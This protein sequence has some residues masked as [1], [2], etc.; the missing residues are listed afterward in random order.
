MSGRWQGAVVAMAI[1]AGAVFPAGAAVGPDE[2][3]SAIGQPRG[4]VVHLNTADGE[5]EK[6]L[7]SERTA[8]VQGLVADDAAAQR[9]RR[10]IS[11]A[12]LYGLA[13]AAVWDGRR[14][15]YADNMLAGVIGDLD[16]LGERAPADEE[17][18][19]VLAPGGV[20]VVKRG[21]VLR[22]LSKA[23]PAE[24]DDWGH[25]DHGADGN[26]VSRDRLVRMPRQMQWI[27][28]VKEIKLGGNP[29]G[30][31]P[32]A[33]VRVAGR[34]LV[35]DY[36]IGAGGDARRRQFMLGCYDAFSGVPI[37]K[38]P[39]EA[40][41]AGRRWQLVIEGERIYTFLTK[42]GPL[43]ALEAA[44]GRTAVVY[45]EAAGRRLPEEATH[46]RA[47]GGR[48]LV[49]LDSG[50]HLLEGATG[51]LLWRYAAEGAAVVLPVMD[52]ERKRVLAGL[53]APAPTM[54]GRWP[55]TTAR[56]VVC[57]DL[58]SGRE[59]WRNGEV[60]GRPLG[61][62]IPAGDY[63]AL[64]CGSAISGRGEGG[65]VAAI[66]TRS[67]RLTGEGT[68]KVA[69]NDS[70]YN[71]VV[72]DG[73]IYY[74]GHTSI[75]CAPLENVKISRVANLA[76]NQRCNRF[77]ATAELFIT[78]F[79]TYWDRQFGAVLQSVARSG[80]AIG[81]TPANGM[82]YLTPSACGCFTQL[83][84]YNC[85]T[86]EALPPA[87]PEERRLRRGDGRA[88]G[89]LEA[90]AH[91]ADGAVVDEWMRWGE[92]TALHE[93]AA[94]EGPGGLRISAIV[95]Q[96]R[97]EARDAAGRTRWSF[98]AGGRISA[99]PV[100][101]G[102]VVVAGS[103]DG[104]VYALRAADGALL[105][106]Y[107]AAPAERYIVAYGQLES[108]WPVYGVALMGDAVVASAG[109]HPEIGGGV[110]VAALDIVSGRARW[111]RALEKRPAFITTAGGRSTGAI[112]PRSFLNGVPVVEGERITIGE[113][114]F[115]AGESEEAINGR[116][117]TPPPKKK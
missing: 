68:F 98:V 112:V 44:S 29:A 107:L 54:R 57:L 76:Y 83:R 81:A 80:C 62:I 59:L 17:I 26:S 106:R 45:R 33:G 22:R 5:L 58:E 72:R 14:L 19:R 13:T 41:A 21:G 99:P 92:R 116:L 63:V 47:G 56:A 104:W 2:A 67:N 38:Q 97:L 90:P 114:S 4:V 91:T 79:V 50:L 46:V 87:V 65:W 111:R 88:A 77:V 110:H 84:G 23:R 32:G 89:A 36:S 25:F 11:A 95:H 10:T 49:N 115:S 93:T 102:D 24:M 75:Y 9:V 51:R 34:Y 18:M 12:G 82:V 16:E 6:R 105:W 73:N 3:L 94:A 39:R 55:W 8:L 101:A 42:D 103:H 71:A 20:A 85:L 15:P 61:Q 37:W 28:G 96:H 1:V 66:D 40:G 100:V 109:R 48:V 86:P 43:V 30:Y 31:D 69:W 108:A 60:E 117:N 74:G 7:A 70:M 53:A 35:M 78:G 52:L 113:L 27:S 64:F